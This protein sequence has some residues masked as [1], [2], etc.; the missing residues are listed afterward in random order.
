MNLCVTVTTYKNDL[1]TWIEI[2][3]EPEDIKMTIIL[4]GKER[5]CFLSSLFFIVVPLL[6]FAT[7]ENKYTHTGL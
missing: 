1:S 2:G 7:N 5:D 3:M 6:I 4:G